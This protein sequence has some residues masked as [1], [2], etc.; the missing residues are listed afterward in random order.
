MI[1]KDI[2]LQDVVA[3]TVLETYINH[4]SP[5]NNISDIDINVFKNIIGQVLVSQKILNNY[6]LLLAENGFCQILTDRCTVLRE[7]I[8]RLLSELPDIEFLENCELSCECDSFLEILI[9]SIK[10]SSLSHQHNFF[11]IK[12]AKKINLDKKISRLKLDFNANAG[13]FCVLKGN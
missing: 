2:D 1:L 10:N 8:G 11:K 5:N 4:L 7:T 3:I 6:N 12:N 13:E 9:M